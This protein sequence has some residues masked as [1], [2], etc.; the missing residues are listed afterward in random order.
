MLRFYTT[1]LICHKCRIIMWHCCIHINYCTSCC[2]SPRSNR[3]RTI[4]IRLPLTH[5]S[6]H[7]S[8]ISINLYYV[9]YCCTVTSLPCSIIMIPRTC[10]SIYVK[11][12][13]RIMYIRSIT[14]IVI[15]LIFI[16]RFYIQ[17][18]SNTIITTILCMKS[19]IKNS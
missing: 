15:I 17:M 6:Y 11:A 16:R 14:Y 10:L 3:K 4:I 13:Q 18:H 9:K 8:S 2:C 1:S 19:R 7:I 12:M 5:I